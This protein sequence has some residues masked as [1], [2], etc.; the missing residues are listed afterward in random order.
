MLIWQQHTL[1]Y[2]K[3]HIGLGRTLKQTITET[4]THIANEP[5]KLTSPTFL[6]RRRPGPGQRRHPGPG[7]RRHPSGPGPCRIETSSR[8]VRLGPKK[9]PLGKCPGVGVVV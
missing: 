8:S 4:T 5:K 3:K 2:Y 1:K 7:Q 6:L 9:T